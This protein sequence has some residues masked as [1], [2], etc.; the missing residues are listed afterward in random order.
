MCS[1]DLYVFGIKKSDYDAK[2]KGKGVYPKGKANP[3]KAGI[4][5]CTDNSAF[6]EAFGL[7]K[8]EADCEGAEEPAATTGAA[9]KLTDDSSS[10]DAAEKLTGFLVCNGTKT[11]PSL[12]AKAPIVKEQKCLVNTLSDGTTK[13]VNGTEYAFFVVAVS[14]DDFSTVSWTSK[15]VFDAPSA[16]SIKDATKKT[17]SFKAVDGTTSSQYEIKLDPAAGTAT[18]GSAETCSGT[19]T[20]SPCSAISNKNGLDSPNPVLYISRAG[21]GS[22]LQRLY[23]SAPAGGS[24]RIQPR[25]PQTYDPSAKVNTTDGRIPGDRPAT[26]Y[27]KNSG[28]EDKEPGTKYVVYNNQIFDLEITA[29]G[30]KYYGKV[31]IGDVTYTAITDKEPYRDGTASVNLNIVLQPGAGIVQYGLDRQDPATF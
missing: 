16:D 9:T 17:L 14:G 10:K 6:F 26:T 28:G 3:E 8:S 19:D 1:S 31:F 20:K 18:V 2:A 27:P 11:T 21:T 15:V 22:Y 24:V 30:K 13:L 23:I 29:A 5:R 7:P 4:P 25:G 12:V